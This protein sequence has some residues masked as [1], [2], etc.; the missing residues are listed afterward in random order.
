[1]LQRTLTI[2]SPLACVAVAAVLLLG[3]CS[4]P[5]IEGSALDGEVKANANTTK[6]DTAACTPGASVALAPEDPA[7][8]PKC[9]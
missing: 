5:D 7:K 4:T 2:A 3:A 1:M 6:S 9:A 8:Y